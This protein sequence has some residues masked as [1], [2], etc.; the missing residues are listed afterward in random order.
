M[1]TVLSDSP[2]RL[3]CS[4]GW[5]QLIQVNNPHFPNSLGSAYA[6]GPSVILILLSSWPRILF[7]SHK[8]PINC[9]KR[10]RAG[11]YEL[12]VFEIQVYVS[13]MQC[14]ARTILHHSSQSDF[15]PVL[16]QQFTQPQRV[17][18]DYIISFFGILSVSCEGNQVLVQA[19][20]SPL[21]CSSG[22]GRS[23]AVNWKSQDFL[24]VFA[25]SAAGFNQAILWKVSRLR[26]LNII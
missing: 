9:S 16:E 5:G 3:N 1:A 15:G 23:T 7:L 8:L 12:H 25:F 26:L 11:S 20:C 18:S 24:Y 10:H 21:L 13:P 17:N 6:L 19:S 22:S 4:P 14:L 2:L